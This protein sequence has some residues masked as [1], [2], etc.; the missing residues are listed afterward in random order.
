MPEIT[1]EEANKMVDWALNRA[2]EIGLRPS[3][4]ASPTATLR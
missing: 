2:L 4:A 1:L 3:P